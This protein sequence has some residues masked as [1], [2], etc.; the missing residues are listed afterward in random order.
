[1]QLSAQEQVRTGPVVSDPADSWMRATFG[2]LEEHRAVVRRA[3]PNLGWTSSQLGSAAIHGSIIG[4][5]EADWAVTSTA[6]SGHFE[7]HGPLSEDGFA[8]SL[9]LDYPTAGYQWM[10]PVRTGMVGLYRPGSDT[11]SVVRGEARFAVIDIPEAVLVAEAWQHGYRIEPSR[12]FR[13]GIVPGQVSSER[14]EPITR[15]VAL[16]HRGASVPLPP[17]IQLNHLLLA[18][19]VDHVAR[20][21]G[22]ADPEPFSSHHRIVARARAYIDSHLDEPI[23]I[24]DLAEASFAS[25]R[26]LH[27]AFIDILGE[28][29]LSYVL[30]LRLN[31]IRQ[32][33]AS[34]SEALRTVTMV[35]HQWGISELGRLAARYRAQFGEL[36]SETLARRGQAPVRAAA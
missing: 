9:A 18:A 25:R 2:S 29:P 20:A 7:F 24:E 15:M 21:G 12:T 4:C 36:P 35:S 6:I 26:T 23:A 34:P 33:L 8:I 32:D 27:R 1:M 17:G 5:R 13:Q 30:K 22:V 28:T 16:R 3:R 10:H 19:V 31:R 11:D 14:L